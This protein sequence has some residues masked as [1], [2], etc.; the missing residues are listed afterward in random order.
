[1]LREPL[2]DL[3]DERVVAGVG[4]ALELTDAAKE[5]AGLADGPGRTGRAGVPQEGRN[6]VARDRRRHERQQVDVA[7]PLQM[8]AL[9]RRIRNADRKIAGQSVLNTEIA[10]HRIRLLIVS[11]EDEQV[12]RRRL[13]APRLNIGDA[14]EAE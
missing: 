1:M 3:Q 13:T 9:N 11:L 2:V 6:D 7:R 4:V 8:A 10:L 12:R 14:V 5:V